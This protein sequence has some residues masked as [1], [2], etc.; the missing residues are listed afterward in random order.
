MDPPPAQTDPLRIGWRFEQGA[1]SPPTSPHL[2]ND[3][4]VVVNDADVDG[5]VMV[6]LMVMAV[7]LL[8]TV[9]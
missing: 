1:L 4:G 6:M 9:W 3:F 8:M 2:Q 7:L 5:M